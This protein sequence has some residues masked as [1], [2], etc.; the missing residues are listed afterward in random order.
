[1]RV[2]ICG[3]TNIEDAILCQDLG[4]DALGFIFYPG[5]RR[6]ISPYSAAEICRQLSVFTLKVGVFVNESSD[7]INDLADALGLG[8]VQLHGEEPAEMVK[9]IRHPVI[10]SFR[11]KAGYNFNE[12]RRYE[13]CSYLFDTYSAK[14]YGGT[15]QVFDWQLIP[16]EMCSKMIL[17]GGIS[18]DNIEQIYRLI[19]PGAVDLSSA[20]ES[21][22][23]KKNPQKVKSFFSCV[24]RL[25]SASQD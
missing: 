8:A 20:L 10:K 11:I 3:I 12:V 18:S 24:Q 14:E 16:R 21:Y 25:R 4:A 15:G 7:V 2:K 5:S 1:M 22:P 13:N 19:K 23:G 6:Y 17:A 9:E